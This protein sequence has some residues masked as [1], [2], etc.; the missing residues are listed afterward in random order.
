MLARDRFLVPRP[1]VIVTVSPV[2]LIVTPRH[3]LLLTI[4]AGAYSQVT[5]D[6]TLT[7]HSSVHTYRGIEVNIIYREPS[8]QPARYLQ[9]SE[10]QH[11]SSSSSI[12]RQTHGEL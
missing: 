11:N 10:T 6:V 3:T 5:Q 8:R 7:V 9:H 12:V 1:Q 4:A 2:Q